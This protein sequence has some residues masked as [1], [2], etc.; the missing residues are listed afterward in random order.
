VLAFVAAYALYLPFSGRVAELL[1][2]SVLAV[3]ALA[4]V[5]WRRAGGA[6][7]TDE[8]P[9]AEPIAAREATAPAVVAPVETTP[10][11]AAHEGAARDAALT[12]LHWVAL[13][14]IV[15]F[16]AA[17]RLYALG[18]VPDGFF[19]DE[20][21]VGYNAYSILR[22]GRDEHG[23]LLPLYF[24]AFGEYKNPVYIYAAVLS[25]GA[26]G[27]TEL[28]TRLPAALFGLATVPI[29]FLLGRR[30]AGVAAG[31]IAA[32]LLAISPWH[33]HFSRIAFELIALPFVF[34]LGL[35]LALEAF[36]SG[37]RRDFV[38]AG[39]CLALSLYTYAVAR[40]FVPLFLAGFALLFRRERRAHRRG[41]QAALIAFAAGA[42]PL[43]LYTVGDPSRAGARWRDISGISADRPLAETTG[44]VAHNYAIHFSPEFLFERGDPLKRHAVRGYGELYPALAPWL[45]AGLIVLVVRRRRE[46]LLLLWWLAL[47]PLAA[48]LTRETPTATRTIDAIPV[49]ELIAAVGVLSVAR[50]LRRRAPDSWRAAMVPAVGLALALPIAWQLRGYLRAY[51][52][53]YPA[54]SARGLDGF[55]HGYRE[56]IRF[57]EAHRHEYEL[58]ML[59]ATDTNQSE[60][61]AVFY[62]RRDP[63]E[64]Q[65]TRDTG[66]LVSVPEE[67]GRYPARARILY[68]LRPEDLRYFL[69]QDTR[70]T[71]TAPDG[72]V[73]FHVA[74]I[75]SRRPLVL[76]WLVLG[77]FAREAVESGSERVDPLHPDRLAADAGD[78]A[79]NAYHPQ[80]ANLDLNRLFADRFPGGNPE[81]TCAYLW[82]RV[83]AAR[84]A[85]GRIDV[86]GS[87]DAAT[88]YWNGARVAQIAELRPAQ[89]ESLP[90]ALAAGAN[91]LLV[92]SC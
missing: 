48:S 15:V 29:A 50:L 1:P 45:A 38:L 49:F 89:A 2:L 44:A 80:F 61:L 55:Q 57:M 30:L 65:R 6:P 67:Y 81:E 11:V 88:V 31:L 82:T 87:P 77:P 70:L 28:A 60:T 90:V 8:A 19:C 35:W 16:A 59:T 86:F 22:T 64:Y 3:A 25:V 12:R 85:R 24:R 20:A 56:V 84:A 62:N 4:I 5:G 26:L 18:R 91:D 34:G 14:A 33:V 54:Y 73:S 63:A 92:R 51:F 78:A 42:A 37:R 66:Y 71:V 9:A 17:M 46:D 47:F 76:D 68:A 41:V 74:E 58:L 40:L 39:L 23:T 21:S 36:H 69:G 13:A 52:V 43:V 10:R 72:A 27:L 75:R 53:E 79:W 83:H 32:A 7:D